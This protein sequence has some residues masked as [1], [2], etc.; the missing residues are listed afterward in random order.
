MAPQ[1]VSFKHPN[2]FP[3]LHSFFGGGDGDG[4]GGGGGAPAAAIPIN[5]VIAILDA[6]KVSI[7]PPST[8]TRNVILPPLPPALSFALI[9]EWGTGAF[10]T[11]LDGRP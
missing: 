1:F 5:E 11:K 3:T 10:C 8:N 6:R 9:V 2:T 4:G 7:M